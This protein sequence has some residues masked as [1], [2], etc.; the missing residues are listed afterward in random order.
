MQLISFRLDTTKKSSW[1]CFFS[2]FFNRTLVNYFIF[3]VQEHKV[4]VTETTCWVRNFTVFSNQVDNN[5]QD[6][7]KGER[8]KG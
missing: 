8:I 4:E 5:E 7:Q 2:I 6:T 1:G 3:L